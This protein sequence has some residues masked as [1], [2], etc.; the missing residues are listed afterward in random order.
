MRKACAFILLL[1]GCTA[2]ASA[3]R[4]YGYWTINNG[5]LSAGG[6]TAYQL[7]LNGGGEFAIRKGFSAGLEAGFTGDPR[8][9]YG[10]SMLGMASVNGCY[11][12]RPARD[13][14]LDPFVTMGYTLLFRS[15][16]QNAFNWGAGLNWW[17]L[18]AAALRV[19]FR[20]HTWRH[21]PVRFH[22]WGIRAG[23]SFSSLWP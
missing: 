11:H 18:R 15:D 20:D 4:S 10:D 3:Q 16:T 9:N 7:G 14:R 13:A 2:A 8:R 21:D 17:V 23:V 5:G 12:A 6:R 19:E 22:L 1:L